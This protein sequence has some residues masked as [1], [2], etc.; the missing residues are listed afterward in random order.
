MTFT[1][2]PGRCEICDI[3]HRCDIRTMNRLIKEANDE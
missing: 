1:P 2:R 3:D